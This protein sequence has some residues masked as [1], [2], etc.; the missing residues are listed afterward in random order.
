MQLTDPVS[1]PRYERHLLYQGGRNLGVVVGMQSGGI[2]RCANMRTLL[3]VF[4]TRAFVCA[5]DDG[6][7]GN[8]SFLYFTSLPSTR[9]SVSCDVE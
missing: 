3:L 4:V 5:S 1:L 2:A 9:D 8:G 6:K 7:V